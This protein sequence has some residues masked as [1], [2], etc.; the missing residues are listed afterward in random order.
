VPEFET[1]RIGEKDDGCGRATD[2][3]TE[4]P[5]DDDRGRAETTA[6]H[7]RGSAGRLTGVARVIASVAVNVAFS[8]PWRD[9][10]DGTRVR[11]DGAAVVVE[12]MVEVFGRRC[13]EC[14]CKKSSL[15]D[16]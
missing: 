7:A 9:E 11:A 4:L 12:A 2:P 6:A 16:N 1:T 8:A 13:L 14:V 15:C 5:V 3:P 10:T